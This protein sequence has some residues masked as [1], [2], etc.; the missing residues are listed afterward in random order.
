MWTMDAWGWLSMVFMM[1]WLWIPGVLL[2][3]W[4]FS[5]AGQGREDALETARRTYANGEIG[6]ER[7]L[8][9]V[10]DLEAPA[11]QN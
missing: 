4:L 1:G 7:Y 8:Q 3:W 2:A 9:I 6:R 5:H 10:Q 11:N